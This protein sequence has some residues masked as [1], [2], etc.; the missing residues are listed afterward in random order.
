MSKYGNLVTAKFWLP[1][2]KL[3]VPAQTLVVL[4]APII[5][6][7]MWYCTFSIWRIQ[8]LKG[9]FRF[10]H[11][12]KWT[13]V[14]NLRHVIIYNT[15]KQVC[16]KPKWLALNYFHVKFIKLT[17]KRDRVEMC[18][19]NTIFN[20]KNSCKAHHSSE[21]WMQLKLPHFRNIFPH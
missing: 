15:C 2:R 7:K 9:C 5:R 11:L 19:E 17:H 13:W 3:L 20:E 1:N 12:T 16:T 10:S 8:R 4:Q 21:N 6:I 18:T 14:K